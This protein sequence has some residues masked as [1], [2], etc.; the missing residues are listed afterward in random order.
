MLVFPIDSHL[1]P[2]CMCLF[3]SCSSVVA[4][5]FIAKSGQP[6]QPLPA[7][8]DSLSISSPATIKKKEEQHPHRNESKTEQR[9]VNS[10]RLMAA[11]SCLL[12]QIE[13]NQNQLK[14]KRRN[15]R[16]NSNRNDRGN[17]NRNDR[18]NNRGDWYRNDSHLLSL[19]R[20]W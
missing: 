3:Y 11:D 4:H 7:V 20:Q 9:R 18:G 8:A 1:H 12:T 13:T 10:N 5:W 19:K 17:S 6:H 16:G 14:S 2:F 15:D